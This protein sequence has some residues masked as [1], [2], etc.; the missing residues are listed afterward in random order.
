MGNPVKQPYG[1]DAKVFPLFH[2][3]P[4]SCYHNVGAKTCWKLETFATIVTL[5]TNLPQKVA[6]HSPIVNYA[7]CRPL[8]H[9]LMGT[10]S[11][12]QVVH[13]HRLCTSYGRWGDHSQA[14]AA[15]QWGPGHVP[16]QGVLECMTRCMTQSFGTSGRLI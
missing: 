12:A 8:G 5:D 2:T 1:N 16:Y 9:V 4:I 3:A 13:A 7:D 14:R 6:P 10:T 15:T 11:M